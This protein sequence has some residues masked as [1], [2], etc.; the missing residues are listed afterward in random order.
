MN[1]P[2]IGTAGWS[3]PSQHATIF[4]S[5][6]THLERYS[7]I[8]NCVEVNSS[9][10]RSHRLSTWAKWADSVPE[11]F[12]FA[13]KAPKKITHEVKLDCSLEQLQNFLQEAKI[14]GPKLGPILFQLPPSFSFD[15]SRAKIFFDMLRNQYSASI[16]LEPRHRS[17]FTSSVDHLLE[18]YKIARVAADPAITPE[19]SQP[20]GDKSLIYYRLHGSPRI[21]YSAYGEAYLAGLASSIRER[22]NVETWCIFDNTTLGAAIEDAQSLKQLL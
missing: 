12:R 16:V 19:A 22:A 10:Y 18:G 17:W 11:D 8:L 15:Q 2:R 3:I 20:G 13:V 4:P 1:S 9:F 21:Y 6:G 14:L 7:R 5:A